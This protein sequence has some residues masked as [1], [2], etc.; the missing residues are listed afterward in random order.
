MQMN[1]QIALKKQRLVE[2]LKDLRKEYK[3]NMDAV[4]E[5]LKKE[6]TNASEKMQT[7]TARSNRNHDLVSSA[8]D[9][10]KLSRTNSKRSPLKPRDRASS[11]VV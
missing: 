4:S 10:Q 5:A 2:E 1:Q 9:V 11:A 7:M 3:V 6:T 8:L